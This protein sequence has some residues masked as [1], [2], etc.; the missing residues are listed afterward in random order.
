[1]FSGDQGQGGILGDLIHAVQVYSAL[2]RHQRRVLRAVLFR[3]SERFR[4][5]ADYEVVICSRPPAA[6]AAVHQYQL[7]IGGGLYAGAG[8]D[9]VLTDID[10]NLLHRGD[11]LQNNDDTAG[12]HRAQSSDLPI[13]HDPLAAF[14]MI[15]NPGL[16]RG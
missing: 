7:M 8:E 2:V 9:I 11:V 12:E 14:Q 16:R 6:F 4:E 5:G 15:V 1:M 13:I 3:T 10:A